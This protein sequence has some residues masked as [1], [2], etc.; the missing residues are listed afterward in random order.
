MATA[1]AIDKLA[2][3]YRGAR[4]SQLVLGGDRATIVAQRLFVYLVSFVGPEGTPGIRPMPV[5][6]VKIP[7]PGG[8]RGPS[9]FP[10]CGT[11]SFKPPPNWCWSRSSRRTW[12]IAHMGVGATPAAV[13]TF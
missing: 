3:F 2:A 11:G 13:F 1:I 12:K 6:R 10:P 5:Q 7:K 4:R 9:A 8:G